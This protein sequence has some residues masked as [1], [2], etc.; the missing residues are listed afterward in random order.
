[1]KVDKR[2][3]TVCELFYLGMCLKLIE[4]A[5]IEIDWTLHIQAGGLRS[6]L[7]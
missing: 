3:G 1:L 4:K 6:A 7:Q 5:F 2:K